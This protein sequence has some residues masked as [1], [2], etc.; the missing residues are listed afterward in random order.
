MPW[1]P[2]DIVDA[3]HPGLVARARRDDLEQAVYGFDVLDELSL[4]PL[5][6]EAFRDAG[7]GVW[8]EQRYPSDRDRPRRSA[9]KRCDI[10]LT[11][12]G[13]PLRPGAAF[14]EGTLFDADDPCPPEQAYWLEVKTVAQFDTVG[15]FRRYSA[16]LLAPVAEDVRKLWNDPLIYHAGLLLVLFTADKSIA[17]HDLAA[18]QRR[19]LD[20]AYPV[21]APAVRGLEI[22]DRN[23]NR[24]CAAAVFPV[25][26]G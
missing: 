21:A 5:L 24:H 14:A 11:P 3:V 18:W 20:R 15:P 10:V 8:P 22:S 1:S 2:A 7:Y 26:G 12:D 6:H 25:R 19:C 9:G 13:A 16:E 4:H 17:E 23:G